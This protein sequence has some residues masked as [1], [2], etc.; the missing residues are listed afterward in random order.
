MKLKLIILTLLI[1]LFSFSL[2]AKDENYCN[3]PDANIQ[4]EAL[5]QEH[6]C[7]LQI[8]ALHVLRFGLCFKVDRGDLSVDQAMEMFE[9]MRSALIDMK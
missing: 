8:H 9:N 6:P 2:Q 4:W 1:L 7:D 3:D 5:I